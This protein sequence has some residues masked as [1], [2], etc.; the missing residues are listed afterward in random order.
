[1]ATVAGG[2]TR[3]VVRRAVVADMPATV[4]RVLAAVTGQIPAYRALDPTQLAEVAAIA[5]WAVARILDLWVHDEALDAADLERFSGIGAA[6]AVDGRPLPVVLRAYRVA[7]ADVIDLVV[8]HG[9]GRLTVTDVLA[10]TRLWLASVDAL[11][12]ALHTGYT[13]AT[14]RLTGDHRRALA[15]L[16]DDLLDGRQT[17]PAALA[18][19][20]RA[21]VVTLPARPA[22]LVIEAT[23]PLTALTPAGLAQVAVAVVGPE[24]PETV[25]TGLRGARGVVVAAAVCAD[26]A[27]AALA[28]RRWRGCLVLPR[29]PA[30][31]AR[32]YRL[33]SGALAS[34][35]ERAFADRVLLR[36]GDAQV[37]ALLTGRPGA[38]PELTGRAVLGPVAGSDHPHLVD[39]LDAYLRTGSAAE[40]AQE[41]GVHPQTMRYRLRRLA[42]LTGRD[43]RRPWDRFVL[44]V[45]QTATRGSRS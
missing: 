29:T 13:A 39:G 12:E 17:S 9:R 28:E 23:S 16:L 2:S 14:R 41:L 34:A 22:L 37:L 38:D 30:D 26:R 36:E 20:C 27:A 18:E 3:R 35:P 33:A 45:A 5:R 7:A 44:E 10:L 31:T 11:S 19:R 42:E 40:A 24:P 4:D 21:L 25:L 15:D 6:R 1:M 32:A 43:P 8:E